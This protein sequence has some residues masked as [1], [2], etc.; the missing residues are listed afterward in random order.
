MKQARTIQEKYD[1]ELKKKNGELRQASHIVDNL[2][3]E[4]KRSKD[5]I[6]SLQNKLINV[7]QQ[8]EL[9]EDAKKLSDQPS[10]RTKDTYQNQYYRTQDDSDLKQTRDELK[11]TRA[12]LEKYDRELKRKNGEL[13]QV[14]QIIDNLQQENKRSKD[15]I[16]SLQ[17]ELINVHQQLEDAKNLSEVH[18]TELVDSSSPA[19][20][21]KADTL[22][23]SEVGEKVTA[24][25]EEIFQAA[26]TLGE[27]LVRKHPEVSQTDLDAAAVVSQEMI[28]EKMTK[29]L[30]AQSQKQEPEFNPLLVQV[31]LQI[32]LVR[33]CV[34]KIQS[35][36]SGD[37]AVGEILSAIYSQIRSTGKESHIFFK[38]QVFT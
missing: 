21:T 13:R 4:D 31:V 38:N 9:L 24:L 11:Q 16:S 28:G 17:N 6:S 15:T 26:A 20:L 33:F 3:Q 2:Q 34:S 8:L 14:S 7:H 5:T 36:Y 23:I 1:R 35:W 32:F 27:A 37:P 10:A 29:L 18:E 12:V 22:S 30:I 19:I 25:N